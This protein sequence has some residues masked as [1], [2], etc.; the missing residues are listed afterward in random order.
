MTRYAICTEVCLQKR[1]EVQ[2]IGDISYQIDDIL[3]HD[4]LEIFCI[5]FSREIGPNLHLKTESGQSILPPLLYPP[6]S[7]LLHR[8]PLAKALITVLQI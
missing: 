6:L 1:L 2:E 8:S 3:Y 7:T 4:K 5:K